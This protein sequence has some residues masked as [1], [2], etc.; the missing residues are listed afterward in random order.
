MVMQRRAHSAELAASD[1]GPLLATTLVLL[2][3]PPFPRPRAH[4]LRVP[5]QTQPLPP[6]QLQLPALHSV[7]LRASHQPT[8]L[9]RQQLPWL[10]TVRFH[11]RA[12]G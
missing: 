11:K 7:V 9:L 5:F 8:W 6:P 2:R 12:L 10:Q 3:L 4:P 1:A